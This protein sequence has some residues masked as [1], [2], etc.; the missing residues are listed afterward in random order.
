[1]SGTGG[2]SVLR[3]RPGRIIGRKPL[4][5]KVSE[6]LD[7]A[8]LVLKV[9]ALL[10]PASVKNASTFRPCC[11]HEPITASTRSTNRLP[12]NG[13]VDEDGPS[14]WSCSKGF[15]VRAKLVL[16]GAMRDLAWRP[17]SWMSYSALLP[18]L[19]GRNLPESSG[20]FLGTA[21]TYSRL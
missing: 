1:M 15:L 5:E 18:A 13:F 11:R 16:T 9:L 17:Y 2:A 14:R 4:A 7:V 19:A 8:S 3:S 12:P 20:S 10:L 6:R 21:I